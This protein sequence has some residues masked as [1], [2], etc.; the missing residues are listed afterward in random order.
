MRILLLAA[1]I[2]IAAATADAR[3]AEGRLSTILAPSSTQPAIVVR[4]DALSVLLREDAALRLESSAGSFELTQSSSQTRRGVRA[5]RATFPP[6]VSVG[7]YTL[8]ATSAGGDDRNFRAVFVL[9]APP[10]EYRVAVWNNP[11]VSA[12][13]QSPDTALFRVTAEINAGRPALVLVTG[14]LTASGSPGQFRLA[15]ELLNDCTA[16]TLVAPG[17]AD[18]TAGHAQDYLGDYPVAVPFGSDGY[19]LCSTPAWDLGGEDG[20]LHLERRRIRAA[21][22]SVGVGCNVDSGDL[23]T[24]LAIFVDDPLDAVVG[25]I[26]GTPGRTSPWGPT[27]IFTTSESR[28]ALEWF[29]A[30]ARPIVPDV[31]GSVP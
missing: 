28:G 24:Q 21:R 12:D 29:T 3:D 27:S 22:W 14:D 1:A 30:S 11:R 6:T 13:P 18:A 31:T 10:E 20:R 15:L 2:C 16:P 7:A 23:R 25:A 17:P 5:I 19:L 26:G 8:V 4:G 9:D